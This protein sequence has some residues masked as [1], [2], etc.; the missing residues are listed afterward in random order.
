MIQTTRNSHVKNIGFI[1]MNTDSPASRPEDPNSLATSFLGSKFYSGYELVMKRD[2]FNPKKLWSLKLKYKLEYQS[3]LNDGKL[4]SKLRNEFKN[5]GIIFSSHV[6]VTVYKANGECLITDTVP[7]Y[8][9]KLTEIEDSESHQLDIYPIRNTDWISDDIGWAPKRPY[10]AVIMDPFTSSMDNNFLDH[11]KVRLHIPRKY[12]TRPHASDLDLK[13]QKGGNTFNMTFSWCYFHK[14]VSGIVNNLTGQMGDNFLYEN[15]LF[16]RVVFGISTCTDQARGCRAYNCYFYVNVYCGFDSFVHGAGVTPEIISAQA[17]GGVK[18]LVYDE[19]RRGI[20]NANN[21]YA[22]AIYSPLRQSSTDPIFPI[23]FSNCTFKYLQPRHY[24]VVQPDECENTLPNTDTGYGPFD[25]T[26]C[27]Y[28]KGHYPNSAAIVGATSRNCYIGPYADAANVIPPF[29][30]CTF[31]GCEIGRTYG[32]TLIEPLEGGNLTAQD[33]SSNVYLDRRENGAGVPGSVRFRVTDNDT[34]YRRN[35]ALS[36][37]IVSFEIDE[38]T[39][40]PVIDWVKATVT[41]VSFGCVTLDFNN[42]DARHSADILLPRD[43]FYFS[44]IQHTSI[45]GGG[46]VLEKNGS[47]VRIGNVDAGIY[48]KLR[49]I[50]KQE[51]EE[52]E[53]EEEIRALVYIRQ[54]VEDV[55][56]E[57]YLEFDE[58]KPCEARV[59]Q[60]VNFDDILNGRSSVIS[61]KNVFYKADGQW[62]RV[63]NETTTTLEFYNKHSITG[64]HLATPATGNLIKLNRFNVNQQSVFFRIQGI[65]YEGEIYTCDADIG[66]YYKASY[67]YICTRTVILDK[68]LTQTGDSM[69]PSGENLQPNGPDGKP[70][71]KVFRPLGTI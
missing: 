42:E 2:D 67:P 71:D 50:V 4:S 11:E 33:A 30:H 5:H 46:Q 64:R 68:Y 22:E 57:I 59:I 49:E 44:I 23:V 20:I 60:R 9:I 32:P 19:A 26:P 24:F 6:F 43:L 65:Y 51:K 28:K 7:V 8:S 21:V 35:I 45:T 40:Y 36:K 3:D 70:M 37:N 54:M 18:Y 63:K 52:E 14:F 62:L 15:L 25:T 34:N 61:I 31:Q 47:R 10:A 39:R 16:E 38:S 1:G 56:T 13:D 53:E 12:S 58:S 41:D 17:A 69:S 29:K 48:E 55:A 27:G 66:D